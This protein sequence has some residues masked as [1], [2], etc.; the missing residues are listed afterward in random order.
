MNS[1]KTLVLMALLAAAGYYTYMYMGQK[2]ETA[3]A[4]SQ[5]ISPPPTVQIPGLNSYPPQSASTMSNVT[6]KS[7]GNL[8]QP[9]RC[10]AFIL[11]FVSTPQPKQFIIR[12]SICQQ[13]LAER[14]K[15]DAAESPSPI[16]YIKCSAEHII[17]HSR[18]DSPKQRQNRSIAPGDLSLA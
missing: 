1:M 10:P 18:P 7:S 15:H 8:A 6:G 13:P 3:P 14:L 16:Q 12:Q 17:H 4:D 9:F 5:A 11:K 2:P